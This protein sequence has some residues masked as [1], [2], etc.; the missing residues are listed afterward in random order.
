[1][2]PAVLRPIVVH[3]TILA[4][5]GDIAPGIVGRDMVAAGCG[6]HELRGS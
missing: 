2:L 5:G 1:M 6:R 3:V 4:E